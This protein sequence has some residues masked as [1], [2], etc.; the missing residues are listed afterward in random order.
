MLSVMKGHQM[1]QR[2]L[3]AIWFRPI[4]LAG[5][6][7]VMLAQSPPSAQQFIGSEQ[8]GVCHTDLYKEFYRNPHFKSIAAGKDAPEKTGC[9]GCHG[10]GAAHLAA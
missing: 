2:T 8:C 1:W 4:L 7:T 6:L 3:S 9:E 5:S 10:P